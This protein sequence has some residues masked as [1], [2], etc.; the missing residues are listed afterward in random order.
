MGQNRPW[1]PTRRK[2]KTKGRKAK[3]H[4]LTTAGFWC[5]FPPWETFASAP[6]RALYLRWR[7]RISVFYT[8]LC[9]KVERMKGLSAADDRDYTTNPERWLFRHFAPADGF[10]GCVCV[11]GAYI[12]STPVFF[13]HCCDAARFNAGCTCARA[14]LF[15]LRCSRSASIIIGDP[16]TEGSALVCLS[17]SDTDAVFLC[18]MLLF[19][20]RW[21]WRSVTVA[22]RH[23][24]EESLQECECRRV[25]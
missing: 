23:V 20:R 5:I 9:F 25:L 10:D 4:P 11:C 2:T 13:S 3:V 16:P 6:A 24:G 8:R 18:V 17:V 21:M 1:T 12:K 15:G 7:N 14:L 22:F 19:C